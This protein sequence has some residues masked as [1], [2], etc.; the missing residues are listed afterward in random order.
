MNKETRE[1]REREREEAIEDDGRGVG[2]I[3]AGEGEP[4]LVLEDPESKEESEEA[5]LSPDE[6]KALY[7]KQEAKWREIAKDLQEPVQIHEVLFAEPLRSKRSEEVLRGIQRIYSKITV[8]NLA[9]RR[10][11]SDGG[12]EFTNRGFKAW[13]ASRDIHP[14]YS[15]PGDPKANGRIENAVGR[16]KSGVR[17]LLLS[18]PELK[19][20]SW[21]SAL[22]QFVEQRF[23]ESLAVLGAE[24]PKRAL[25]P[26]G[27]RVMVQSR[28]WSKKT[29]YAPRAIEGVA[30][31]PASNI[32]GCTVV[33]LP[34]QEGDKQPRFHVA[35]VAYTGIKDPIKFDA[36]VG[37]DE[38]P[39]PP[40]SDAPAVK[41]RVSS[42]RPV[43]DDPHLP[44]PSDP[45]AVKR[46]VSSKRPVV[47][48]ACVG[49]ESESESES[50]DGFEGGRGQKEVVLLKAPLNSAAESAH[51]E[52][53]LS[54]RRSSSPK[55]TSPQSPGLGLSKPGTK[56]LLNAPH[57]S[58][59]Q[60]HQLS[61]GRSARPWSSSRP[62]PGLGPSKPGT[63]VGDALD[64]R[65]DVSAC[66]VH[67]MP[68]EKEGEEEEE[69][70]EECVT[71]R[72][73]EEPLGEHESMRCSLCG[74]RASD[75][76]SV[77]ESEARAEQLLH[78]A[79]V[80]RREDVDQLIADSLWRWTPNTRKVDQSLQGSGALGFTLGFYRH[81]PK[82][83]VTTETHRRPWLTQ[84]VNRYMQQERDRLG[85]PGCWCSVRVTS[86]FTSEIHRDRNKPGS[87]NFVVPISRFGGGRI[88]IE[89]ESSSNS[90]AR[91]EPIGGGVGRYV[92][93]ELQPVWFD[94]SRRHAV[95]ASQ[96][97]RRVLVG[98][99][100][101]ELGRLPN[102]LRDF[103]VG[104]SFPLPSPE[105][106]QPSGER[107]FGNAEHE[108]PDLQEDVLSASEVHQLRCEHAMLR[109]LLIE[110][111]KCYDEEVAIAAS[112]GWTAPS[113]HLHDLCAW[114]DE[115][116]QG[117]VWQDTCDLL[118]SGAVG[119]AEATVLGARLA[120]L[121][122]SYDSD[123][124]E[125]V[126]LCKEDWPGDVKEGEEVAPGAWGAEPA[127][128]L[129]T[130]SVSHQEVLKKIEDWK[131]SIVDELSNVFDVHEAMR[132]RG[133]DDLQAWR[134]AGEQVEILP[135][136]ALFHKKG[137][138][139]RHKCRV[140]A[141]GNFSES[142]KKK[143]RDQKL[144]CYAGGADSLSLR[145]HLR[146]A[147]HRACS[148]G[149][150]TSGADIRTAFLL[151][152]LRR[153]NKRI[154]LRPP[155]V[156]VQAGFAAPGEYW[157]ITGAL[158]GLAES[159][160]DWATY[161]DETLPTIDIWHDNQ[162]INLQRSRYDQNLWLLYCPTTSKLI[163][164]LTIYVDD[165]LLSGTPEASEAVWA[166]IKAKWKISEPEYADQ[167]RAVTF[168]GFEI[169]QE[170]DGI[171]V[172]QAKYIQ[173][174]LDKYPE[175]QGTTSCPYARE[176]EVIESKPQDSIEKLRR[177]QALVG[178]TLWLATRT[179][180]DLA[181]GVSR[182][183]QLIT[184][185]VDQALRRGE[186][187]L[188]YLRATKGQELIYGEPGKG[189]GTADQ[190]PVERETSTLLKCLRTLASVLVPTAVRVALC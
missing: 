137:G 153:Q 187:M 49:G 184:R 154:V 141:C 1:R 7:E 159:P 110:Q 64:A 96:G 128:P 14:T 39:L 79:T 169:R 150:R 51:H 161:R 124:V 103:L 5:E 91:E 121:G 167:G 18:A 182:L 134:D 165:L 112:E 20:S 75:K 102:D 72:V 151:A 8:M 24:K 179:R 116:E 178:E 41:R 58:T 68:R 171:H 43:V 113:L 123:T 180:P 109:H 78:A 94:A 76:L 25:P 162:K 177:A 48:H 73:C 139:G 85:E 21:P 4:E 164:A 118:K 132:R 89:E 42:K 120:R 122:I 145:C 185:D 28:S 47:A 26:F 38:P 129:Q 46:R 108:S 81:G 158:Y 80:L 16:V 188:K 90:D 189:H 15:P 125:E 126:P 13:C 66:L 19:K 2:R 31:C 62:S 101:K 163:A 174:L 95:E 37:G 40:P 119:D 61:P 55:S 190:L 17:A 57:N 45:P 142:A 59:R 138:S 107:L 50:Q 172:G 71:C 69:S 148:H 97:T 175:V 104:L 156:L 146:A 183:G 140:V 11:H 87:L 60:E 35:P 111:H 98:Y 83:G 157:E 100:P 147:G 186:D 143:S 160:A 133:E 176:S 29:P 9:V 10:T 44:P 6:Y 88:W 74:L 144:Q 84:V 3:D 106:Q 136:K 30:L 52:H 77:L 32:T 53:Q 170:S 34:E 168:C 99:T 33:L 181:F 70:R 127:Q 23:R 114:I 54:L 155:S 173:S 130:I 86:N 12:R 166:A 67:P 149:W 115:C 92:G 82:I 65:V 152:P 131:A 56:V 22:R 93:G 63:A 117:L 36:D 27:A 135:A 105:S